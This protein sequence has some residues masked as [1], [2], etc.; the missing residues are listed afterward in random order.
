MFVPLSLSR[1]LLLRNDLIKRFGG[2][3]KIRGRILCYACAHADLDLVHLHVVMSPTRVGTNA[4][5][6]GS[7]LSHYAK[8]P[9]IVF[10]SRG[11]RF[12]LSGRSKNWIPTWY[13][14]MMW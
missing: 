11:S 9:E 2:L 5:C 12:F 10:P 1:F 3:C 13:S 6:A 8:D 14:N 7:R 4:A